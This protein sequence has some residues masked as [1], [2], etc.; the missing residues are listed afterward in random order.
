MLDFSFG[1]LVLV[2]E[3]HFL[4]LLRDA[5]GPETRRLV[6]HEVGR[7]Y[8]QGSGDDIRAQVLKAIG[9]E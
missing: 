2:A 4:G 6:K 5:L 7:E 1:E 8:T 9:A 3:P